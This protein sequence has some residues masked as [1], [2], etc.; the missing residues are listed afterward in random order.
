M[1]APLFLGHRVPP[2]WD[3]HHHLEMLPEGKPQLCSP[4]VYF[5]F[6]WICGAKG[7][8]LGESLELFTGTP[9]GTQVAGGLNASL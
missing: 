7:A 1:L 2:K 9:G 8:H 5:L 4:H 3:L 6:V